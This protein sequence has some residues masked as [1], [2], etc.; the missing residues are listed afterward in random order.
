M[1]FSEPA[2][3]RVEVQEPGGK[4][5]L[6]MFRNIGF[7][8]VAFCLIFSIV[9]SVMA[10]EK[11]EQE[12]NDAEL[13]KAAIAYREISVI[14]QKFQQSVQQASNHIE[15]KELQKQANKKMVKAVEK[16]GL[17]VERYNKIMGKVYKD[18][19]LAEKFGS[20]MDDLSKIN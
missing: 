17:D 14:N 20:K 10:Q 6:G 3:R 2:S 9:T 16:S 7:F 13:E 5:G 8:A 15:R 1:R 11:T 19:K 18:E 12:V 4:G